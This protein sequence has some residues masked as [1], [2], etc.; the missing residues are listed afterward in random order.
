MIRFLYGEDQFRLNEKLKQLKE[1]FF[2]K[3]TSNASLGVFDFKEKFLLNFS[4]KT[5]LFEI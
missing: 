3:N 5:I 1:E 2:K 4:T